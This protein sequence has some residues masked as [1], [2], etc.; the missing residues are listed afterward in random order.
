MSRPV[1]T[2][3]PDV[4]AFH[5]H[6]DT[7]NARRIVPWTLTL[8]ALLAIAAGSAY[9]GTG[10]ISAAD[11]NLLGIAVAVLQLVLAR[12]STSARL[13][14]NVLGMTILLWG[15]LSAVTFAEETYIRHTAHAAGGLAAYV[16]TRFLG[17]LAIVW[18]P[19]D[20]AIGLA[21]THAVVAPV[22]AQV[23][24]QTGFV[25]APVWSMVAWFAAFLIY[26]AERNA[27]QA[28]AV[29]QQ[30]RDKLAE[31]NAR[32]AQLNEEKND[33]MAIA[34][35]DLRS[36]LM[37]MTT[38]LSLTAEEMARVWSE[39]VSRI[40]ALEQSCHDMAALVSRVLDAHAAE[41]QVGGLTLRAADVQP[42]VART[43]DAHRPRAAAKDIE[44][45]LE[46]NGACVVI[47]DE[48]ALSRVLD[49]LV[50]NAVK[51]TPRGGRVTV[52]VESSGRKAAIRVK[53]T[54]PG[55]RDDDRARLFRKFARLHARPTTGESSSGLGLY[56]T[57][58]LT[59]AM[60]G[61]IA[62]GPSDA[63]AEFIVTL[64]GASA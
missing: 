6:L 36:P 39:G 50:S 2:A 4:N 48:P 9:A 56:I 35:H 32:L 15:T 14:A 43:V 55:I 40:K 47:H 1:S 38:L 25:L 42:L 8:I 31:A 58:R 46:S 20:L 22:M 44:V 23:D 12:W 10:R 7:I 26:R 49:N 11:A 62:L 57:K 27:F 52:A 41:D 60:G 63:G 45:A 3:S 64:R 59:E 33:L 19:V 18:R 54:G 13:R 17:A 30:E 21:V 29:L 34:A 53:D 37:G 51:F 28:R 16:V 24:G 5:A 61:S